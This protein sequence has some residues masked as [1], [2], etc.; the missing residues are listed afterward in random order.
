MPFFQMHD[1]TV[2]HVSLCGPTRTIEVDG[3]LYRFEDHPR[4]GPT[5]LNKRGDPKH[6][7]QRHRFWTAITQWYDG[8]KKLDANGCA[9]WEEAADPDEAAGYVRVGRNLFPLA[10]AKRLGYV[11][12]AN[13]GE[14]P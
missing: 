8:G 14:K 13:D 9:I 6:L 10:M 11:P 7:G 1:G 4:C 2:A 3:K 5:P 12:P